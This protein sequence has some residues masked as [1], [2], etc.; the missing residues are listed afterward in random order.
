MSVSKWSNI[1]PYV[2]VLAAVVGRKMA[3]SAWSPAPGASVLAAS[4]E[5]A[6]FTAATLPQSCLVELTFSGD[7]ALPHVDGIWYWYTAAP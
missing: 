4:L 5:T 6:V 2:R 7:F 3:T 1:E